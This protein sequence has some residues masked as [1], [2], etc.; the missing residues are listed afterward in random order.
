[1]SNVHIAA[2]TNVIREAN[3]TTLDGMIAF[4]RN[5]ADTPFDDDQITKLTELF[6]EYKIANLAPVKAGRGK[7]N[8]DPSAPKRKVTISG[9]SL[10]SKEMRATIVA[11][12][13][14]VSTTEVMSLL[15]KAWKSLPEDEKDT[16]KDRAKALNEAAAA[17]PPAPAASDAEADAKPA[18]AAKAKAAKGAKKTTASTPVSDDEEESAEAKPAKSTK[19]PSTKVTKAQ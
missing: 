2:I 15:G 16:Y 14:G 6:A 10:F 4:V 5:H 7:K 19:K 1:M 12:N 17:A 3:A 13:K 11:E 9:Y 18:K 8:V